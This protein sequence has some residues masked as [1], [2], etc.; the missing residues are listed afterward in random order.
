VEDNWLAM[1][2]MFLEFIATIFPLVSFDPK[3]C[4]RFY[5]CMVK[6][7]SFYTSSFALRYILIPYTKIVTSKGTTKLFLDH[8][9]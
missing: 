6:Y 8:V 4:L 1:V 3:A 7:L 5:F 2:A 9:F